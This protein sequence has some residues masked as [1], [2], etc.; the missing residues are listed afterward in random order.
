MAL[1]SNRLKKIFNPA[2]LLRQ[3]VALIFVAG[4]PPYAMATNAPLLGNQGKKGHSKASIFYGADEYLSEL[5]KNMPTITKLRRRRTC[6]RVRL[7]PM[8]QG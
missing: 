2:L 3:S 4:F 1:A 6:F 7:T 5:K 8:P